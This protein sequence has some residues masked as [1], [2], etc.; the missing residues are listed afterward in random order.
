[1][2]ESAPVEAE[3]VAEDEGPEPLSLLPPSNCA[4]RATMKSGVSISACEQS[5]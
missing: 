1:M 3:A 4:R 2:A 5:R